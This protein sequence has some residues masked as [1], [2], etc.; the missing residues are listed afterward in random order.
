MDSLIYTRI[1]TRNIL[2]STIKAGTHSWNKRDKRDKRD[3]KCERDK[4]DKRDKTNK[5]DKEFNFLIP[6]SVLTWNKVFDVCDGLRH[7]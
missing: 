2:P 4:R 3:K 7:L 1:Y 6:R 5:R